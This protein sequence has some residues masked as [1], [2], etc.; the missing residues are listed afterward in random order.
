MIGYEMYHPAEAKVLVLY[1]HAFEWAYGQPDSCRKPSSK[2]VL[3]VDRETSAKPHHL[4]W[5]YHHIHRCR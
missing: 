1:S 5:H 4:G 2:L 3:V